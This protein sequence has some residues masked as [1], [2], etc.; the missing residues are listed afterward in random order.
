VGCASWSSSIYHANSKYFLYT[1]ILF[2]SKCTLLLIHKMLKCTVKISHVCSYIFRSN[3]TILSELML[4]PAKATI[5]WNWSVKIHHYMICGVVATSISGC[6]VCTAHYT[7]CN[8]HTTA[9][10]TC[11]HNTANHITMYFYRSTPHCSS[12]SKAQHKLPEDCPIGPRHIGA[13]IEIF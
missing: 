2:T 9:W 12:F 10:N 7:A 11:C 3:W 13:N 1:K 4:S 5:L 8:T 6:G